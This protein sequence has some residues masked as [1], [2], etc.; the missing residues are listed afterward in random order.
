MHAVADVVDHAREIAAAVG[1]ELA[2][3]QVQRKSRAVLAATTDFAAD[4]DDLLD[5]RADIAGDIAIV[6]TP[7]WLGHQHLDVLADELGRAVTEQALGGRVDVLDQSPIANGDDG[8]NGRL[9]DA[10]E[11][12]RLRRR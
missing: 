9:Q 4:A 2:D 5:A 3:R 10:A 11:L 8:R 1:L 12:G 6:L 7:I